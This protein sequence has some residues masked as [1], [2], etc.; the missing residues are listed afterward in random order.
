MRRKASKVWDS[1]DP[2]WD[3]NDEHDANWVDEWGEEWD[4]EGWGTAE[5]S[6]D[7]YAWSSSKA[8]AYSLRAEKPSKSLKEKDE[9]PFEPEPTKSKK[10]VNVKP[11]SKSKSKKGENNEEGEVVEGPKKKRVSDTVVTDR[12]A[13]KRRTKAS[14]VKGGCENR[15]KQLDDMVAFGESFADFDGEEDLR[16][17][18][19]DKLPKRETC[20]LN[21]YKPPR[22]YC[23]VKMKGRGGKDFAHFN[24]G[25][26][27]GL[28]DEVRMAVTCK[29]ADMLVTG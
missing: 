1:S 26:V 5:K 19:R 21:I 8:D 6:W 25:A 27:A 16:Q 7:G 10:S 15:D 3:W 24:T 22:I 20:T 17:A 23:G 11:L 13:P 9:T 12:A 28:P 2:N 29:A 18:I 14:K 4:F